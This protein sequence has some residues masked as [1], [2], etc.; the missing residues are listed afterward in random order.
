VENRKVE[1]PPVAETTPLQTPAAKSN[2]PLTW[3]IIGGLLIII[4]ALGILLIRKNK[5]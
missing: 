4:T 2:S 3:L 1:P 5:P